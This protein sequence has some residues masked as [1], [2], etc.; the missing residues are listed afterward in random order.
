ME[1]VSMRKTLI[2]VVSLAMCT[3]VSAQA[4]AEAA[5]P[6]AAADEAP[7]ATEQQA[8]AEEPKAV[9]EVADTASAE[10]SVTD[11]SAAATADA[12]AAEEEAGDPPAWFRMDHDSYNLQLW[13]GATHTI[14]GV[15]IASDIYVNS[16]DAAE[17]DIGPA[18]TLGDVLLTPMI[19]VTFDWSEKRMINVVPQLYT[20]YGSG[21]LYLENWIQVFLN[22]PL[23]DDAPDDFYTR[24]F[25]T[26][27]V[28]PHV[29][30][31]PQVEAM[32]ALNDNFVPAAGGNDASGREKGLSSLPVGG[33]INMNYGAGNTLGLFLGYETQ[34]DAHIGDS[35][36]A[37]RFTFIKTW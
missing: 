2:T 11:G 4:F 37:G 7:A 22:S 26:Y 17:F 15:D 25:V 8:P 14:G 23:T 19:G 31:G 10:V 33:V 6:V 24:L 12:P 16:A 18:F 27:K 5:A 9:L 36:L 3:L 28:G 35:V 20:I 32:V 13:F 29:A 30:I 1:T 34:K 21:D